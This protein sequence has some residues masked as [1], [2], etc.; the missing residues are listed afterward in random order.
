MCTVVKLSGAIA[1]HCEEG[2]AH[3]K[4]KLLRLS[5]EIKD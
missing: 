1:I 5:I 2:I 3:S 4:D